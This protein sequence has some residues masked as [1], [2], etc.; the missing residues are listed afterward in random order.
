MSLVFDLTVVSTSDSS[1]PSGVPVLRDAQ[2]TRVLAAIHSRPGGAGVC[3]MI[4]GVNTPAKL[5]SRNSV[6]SRLKPLPIIIV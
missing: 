3:L 2:S 1:T 5:K 4:T 6:H